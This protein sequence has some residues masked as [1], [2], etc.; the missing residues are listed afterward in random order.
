MQG[1]SDVNSQVRGSSN[2]KSLCKALSLLKLFTPAK[3]QWALS[4][5]AQ[6]LDYHKSSVQRLV[7]TLEAE[8]FLERIEPTRGV[9]RLGPMLLMLGNVASEGIDLR[10]AAHPLLLQLVDQTQETS[11]LCVVDQSQCYYLDKV[12]SQQAIRISTYIGQRLPLHCSAVGKALM[13]GMTEGEVEIIIAERGLPGFTPT[14]ITDKKNLFRELT[15]IREEKLAF[16]NEEYD[17][18]LRCLAAPVKDSRG[19]VVAAISVSGPV[20]RL[21]MEVVEQYATFVKEA[22]RQVSRRLGY[23]EENDSPEPSMRKAKRSRK[24]GSP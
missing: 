19:Q 23:A 8:G 11:H 14:T 9:F 24:T 22:A 1:Q 3:T 12:D 2:V 18:G 5:M 16:D 10:S 20:Q 4:E 7:T 21:S 15:K 13:S 6:A 17:I